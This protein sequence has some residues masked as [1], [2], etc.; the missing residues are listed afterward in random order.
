MFVLQ[1]AKDLLETIDWE[2]ERWSSVLQDQAVNMPD[3][4]MP[5]K[6]LFNT[7]FFS[8]LTFIMQ[9]EINVH[10]LK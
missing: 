9:P 1:V 4:H 8:M 5:P 2:Q 7:Y 10:E 3:S 6:R